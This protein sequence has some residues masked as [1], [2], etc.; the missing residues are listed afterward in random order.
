MDTLI[1]QLEHAF[2][3]IGQAVKFK[4]LFWVE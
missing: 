2:G 1:V 4:L 3:K